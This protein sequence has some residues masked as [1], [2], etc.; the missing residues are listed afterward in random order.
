MS[1]IISSRSKDLHAMK[2]RRM[3]RPY[4]RKQHASLHGM[5]DEHSQDSHFVHFQNRNHSARTK[6]MRQSISLVR[7]SYGGISGMSVA[8]NQWNK[9]EDSSMNRHGILNLIEATTTRL[10]KV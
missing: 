3:D 6:A 8:A 4:R 9:L 5:F 10:I 2:S 7:E 1:T